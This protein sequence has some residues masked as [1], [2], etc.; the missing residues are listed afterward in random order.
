VAVNINLAVVGLGR[1]G[2]MHAQHTKQV[3]DEIEG[4]RLAALV[5]PDLEKARRIAAEL[6]GGGPDIA[7]FPSV[8]ALPP[9]ARRT[10]RWFAPRRRYH[11]HA[12]M[13]FAA[14]AVLLENR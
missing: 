4:C 5:E 1:I 12:G 9:P 8:D 6:K 10:L 14:A 11:E 3:A 7:V 13:S 2:A